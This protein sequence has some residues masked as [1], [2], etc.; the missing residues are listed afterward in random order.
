MTTILSELVDVVK[1]RAALKNQTRLIHVLVLLIRSLYN[2]FYAKYT[3]LSQTAH[4]A[5]RHDEVVITLILNV[6]H[7][8][9]TTFPGVYKF[10]L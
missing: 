8:V 6:G 10:S 5:E 2:I 7:N 1:Y 4:C 3:W 9:I